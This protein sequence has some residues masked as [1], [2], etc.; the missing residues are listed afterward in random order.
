MRDQSRTEESRLEGVEAS[1]S[2][3]SDMKWRERTLER[4][5]HI[6]SISC[7]RVAVRLDIGVAPTWSLMTNRMRVFSCGLADISYE[8]DPGVQAKI[9]TLLYCSLLLHQT[10]PSSLQRQSLVGPCWPLDTNQSDV[11]YNVQPCQ[12]RGSVSRSLAQEDLPKI[13][14]QDLRTSQTE[15]RAL[16]LKILIFPSFPP[17]CAFHIHHQ[18]RAV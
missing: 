4:D 2:V 17:I 3:A 18:S 16:P 10:G 11:P 8:K 15:Q 5:A 9:R 13:D 6:F 12:G 14:D 7:V 1:W